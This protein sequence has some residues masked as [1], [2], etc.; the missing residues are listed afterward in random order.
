[1][2]RIKNTNLWKPG[3]Y[4]VLHPELGMKEAFSGSF[5]E[6]CAFETKMRRAN[7]AV[8]AKNGWALD[9]K[10]I[11]EYV[12]EYNAKLCISAGRTDLVTYSDMVEVNAIVNDPTVKKNWFGSVAGAV[13]ATKA[14]IGVYLE[15][16]GKSGKTV[17]SELAESRAGVCSRC[18]QNDTEGG[19]GKYFVKKLSEEI[20]LIYG[21]LKDKDC[22]TKQ[23]D[24]LG[25]CKA[26]LCPMKAKVWAH[27][28]HIRKEMK[29]EQLAKLD[30]RC[31]ITKE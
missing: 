17:P 29:S 1:M 2:V 3:G 15:M 27:I 25:V 24:K 5:L 31:W 30:P 4:Q 10:A 7:P 28:D 18:P 12:S 22:H 8:S 20:M 11:A 21:M 26:C 19:L 9:E 14:G 16:F 6:A 13:A 23:D